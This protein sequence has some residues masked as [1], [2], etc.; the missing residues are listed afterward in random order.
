MAKKRLNLTNFRQHQD[1]VTFNQR[2]IHAYL[3]RVAPVLKRIHRFLLIQ[4]FTQEQPYVTGDY[5]RWVIDDIGDWKAVVLR[6]Q[7]L[8]F[9]CLWRISPLLGW[10]V[11][12]IRT[13]PVAPPDIVQELAGTP[14]LAFA[15]A[16]IIRDYANSDALLPHQ[17]SSRPALPWLLDLLRQPNKLV[18]H[19]SYFMSLRPPTTVGYPCLD[20]DAIWFFQM[21]AFMEEEIY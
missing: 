13:Y 15:N 3:L 11:E 17:H 4:G 18:T 7:A 2:H 21:I 14:A 6:G 19:H 1:L 16:S 5:R 9:L 10:R 8:E 12:I 20:K